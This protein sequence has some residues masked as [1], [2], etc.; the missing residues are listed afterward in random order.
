MLLPPQPLVADCMVPRMM[1]GAEWHREFVAHLEPKP[2]RLLEAEV[3]GLP[4]RH[5][6]HGI[7][8]PLALSVPTQSVRE[9]ASDSPR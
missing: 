4:D 6:R 7:L 9:T 2:S 8:M 3:T 5:M 1:N